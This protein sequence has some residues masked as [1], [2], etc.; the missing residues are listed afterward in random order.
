MFVVPRAVNWYASNTD[1]FSDSAYATIEFVDLA[2]K[3]LVRAFIVLWV[4]VVGG[5]FA[6]FLNVV[7]WRLPQGRGIV[8]PSKCPYCN[9]KLSFTA[10]LPVFGW[11]SSNGR[12]RTCKLPISPRYLIVEIILGMVFL[13]IVT[14]E[15][16][17][18]GVNLPLR[19]VNNEWGIE[20]TMTSPHPDL[21][22][23]TLHHLTLLCLLFTIGLVRLDNQ[24]VP[25]SIFVFG[26]VVGTAI[27]FI[28]PVVQHVP[29]PSTG[30]SETDYSQIGL[31]IVVGIICGLLCGAIMAW[32]NRNR[33]SSPGETWRECVF[34]FVLLGLFMGSQ[35]AISVVLAT[36]LLDALLVVVGDIR[37]RLFRAHPILKTFTFTLL[38][39]L[40]WRFTSSFALWP[41]PHSTV[42]Q[43]GGS[44]VAIVALSALTSLIALPE[45][46][47]K[48]VGEVI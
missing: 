33:S 17:C 46:H 31:N 39:M 43:L 8:G 4:F 48:T 21:I 44:I 25:G 15:L 26:V 29:W 7:A 47:E 9:N 30:T 27:Q 19:P 41:G 45:E 5:C 13:A 14:A 24:R 22:Q 16:F 12:C 35:F 37:G 28:C 6:S 34:G 20:L 2:H 40:L 36:L 42:Q 3:T 18:G 10:N 1:V 11:I 23:T 38:L 32:T